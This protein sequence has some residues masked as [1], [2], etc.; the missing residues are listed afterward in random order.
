MRRAP[1]A[2]ALAACLTAASLPTPAAAQTATAAKTSAAVLPARTL[3]HFSIPSVDDLRERYNATKGS[4]LLTGPETADLREK[5]MA[6]YE[7]ASAKLE[8][9]I[10]VGLDDILTVA[11]DE[12]SISVSEP[13]DGPLALLLF[14]GFGEDSSTVDALTDKIQ[15][16]YKSQGGTVDTADVGGVELVNAYDPNGDVDHEAFSFNYFIADG[17]WVIGTNKA[18]LE[19]VVERWGGDSDDTLASDEQFEEMMERVTPVEGR[20]P[21]L[22]SYIDPLE[23]ARSAAGV[24]NQVEPQAGQGINMALGFLPLTGLQNLVAAS[25]ATD[26]GDLDDGVESLGKGFVKIN[27]PTNG[28]LEVFKAVDGEQ[29]PPS[30]VS[31]DAASYQSFTW[32]VED[33]YNA[34][35][36]T[37]DQFQG[38]GATQRQLD[39]IRDMP[40]GPGIDIKADVLDQLEGTVRTATYPNEGTTAQNL[41][42]EDL[43]KIGG[44]QLFAVRLKRTHNLGETI[45]KVLENAPAEVETRDFRGTTIY[46][47]DMDEA[48][49]GGFAI[50]NDHLLIST[51]VT[52]LE[53]VLREG[54]SP[55]AESDKFERATE[56]MPL[57]G[58]GLIYND[59]AAQ[60]R[61]PYEMARNGAFDDLLRE[62][63]DDDFPT[64]EVLD[65]VH[66]LPAFADI[67]KYFGLGAAYTSVEDDGYLLI[68]RTVETED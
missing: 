9:E 45:G 52:V 5:F 56:D 57:D 20:T 23:L 65:I 43:A 16:A 63:T 24:V 42:P 61:G 64:E 15:D 50:A 10:G 53:K 32:A 68:Q 22:M 35:E 60:L 21:A 13:D 67:A 55:L 28:L 14:I 66:D 59:P 25:S 29:A 58:A 51:D 11:E 4:G 41:T 37:I 19:S 6:Q 27:K 47:F 2:A 18:A 38:R 12:F 62:N 8:S 30:W 26:F 33:A 7:Q 1:A 17:V 39:Q 3:L 36:Q 46:E 49:V 44:S 54:G 31:D 48:G 40:G 34:I